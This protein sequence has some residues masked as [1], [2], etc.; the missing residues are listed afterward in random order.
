MNGKLLHPSDHI[1]YL[2]IYLDETLSAKKHCE[3]LLQKLNRANGILSKSRHYVSPKILKE[4]YY[5][6]FPPHLTYG[7]QIWGQSINTYI[8]KISIQGMHP[9]MHAHPRMHV[10][11]KDSI[12]FEGERFAL[13]K[14]ATLFLDIYVFLFKSIFCHSFHFMG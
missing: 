14:W 9:E 3:E 12:N 10:W 2:R 11:I 7:S 6:I 1:K 4:I 8:D 5:T 13:Y